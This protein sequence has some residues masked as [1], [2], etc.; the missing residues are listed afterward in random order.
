MSE[1]AIT[2][3]PAPGPLKLSPKAVKRIIHGASID[4]GWEDLYTDD[5]DEL[6][7]VFPKVAA[8]VAYVE[9]LL[10]GE[11]TEGWAVLE[12]Q[13]RFRDE[14]D[15]IS[16]ELGSELLTM[17]ELKGKRKRRAEKMERRLRKRAKHVAAALK[18]CREWWEACC[19]Y[20]RDQEAA[21]RLGLV[22]GGDC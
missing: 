21:E 4:S 8:N 7:E 2:M 16:K 13:K 15:W 3:H 18:D 22:E 14:W 5:P 12:T 9:M 11:L 17:G 1:P 10:S 6:L 19:Q 20:D